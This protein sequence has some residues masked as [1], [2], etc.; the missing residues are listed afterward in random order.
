MFKFK[1]MNNIYAEAENAVSVAKEAVNYLNEK[2]NQAATGGDTEM[3]CRISAK[4][5]AAR[6]DL[7][8]KQVKLERLKKA[9]SEDE[10]RYSVC[11]PVEIV[12]M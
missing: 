6:M 3:F 11:G 4:L 1:Y 12:V 9:F 10:A 8:K 5:C 7:A 2:F